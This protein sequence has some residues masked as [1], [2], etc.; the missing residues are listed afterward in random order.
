M[1]RVAALVLVAVALSAGAQELDD[2][3]PASDDALTL[4]SREVSGNM[5]RALGNDCLAN[6]RTA[7][8][9]RDFETGQV[10]FRRNGGVALTPASNM[11][12]LTSA[13]A[14]TLLGPEHVRSTRLQADRRP[15]AD[16]GV[17]TLYFVG[18]GDP[19][20]NVEALYVIARA[21]AAAGVRR[22]DRIVADDSYFTGPLR[23]PSWPARNHHYWYGAPASALSAN[24]NV[25]A[26]HA[27]ADRSGARPEAWVDPFP[28]FFEVSNTLR[29][30]RGPM[31]VGS[32][33]LDSTE[34]GK[35]QRLDVSGRVRPGRSERV[36]RAVESPALF[37]AHGLQDSLR[38]VGIDV[39]TPPRKGLTPPEAVLLHAH[40]SK[41]LG[42]LIHDMNKQSSNVFAETLL[43]V[44]GAE[45]LG[46]PGS[47]E[48]GLA[49]IEGFLGERSRN[50]EGL[51]LEDGSG[52]SPDNR[53]SADAITDLILAM[54]EDALVWPEF[55]VT[56]P[57]S[58]VDGTLRRRLK[59]GPTQRLVRAKTGRLGHVVALSGLAPIGEG[60]TA[61]FSVLVNDYPCPTWKVQDA[62]D[63]LV[64]ALTAQAPA[65]ERP[66]SR[67]PAAVLD[68]V[69]DDGEA[70][71]AD[72]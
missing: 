56:L 68:G 70:G 51:A 55:L 48:N 43:K 37:A 33:L 34:T 15:D 49:V 27:R 44:L 72:E 20:L 19:S 47:R 61:V 62:V 45:L 2:T 50:L 53:I 22:V 13:A 41:P 1:S 14:L 39:A 28:A 5:K 71:G 12:L 64:G 32:R 38:R 21:L 7:V 4:V 57:V 31:S 40:S 59:D 10:L 69:N 29:S 63:A 16:G 66:R 26:I 30:G 9:V 58:G 52:L 3:A 54:S 36:L 65:A 17:G 60:R 8:V 6:A 24:Y 25:V 23:V 42:L 18:H 46:P 35:V 67:L 11:K